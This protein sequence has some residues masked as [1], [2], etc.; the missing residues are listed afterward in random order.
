MLKDFLF[1]SYRSTDPDLPLKLVGELKNRGKRVWI[2]RLE[3]QPG[4][5]WGRDIENAIDNCGGMIVVLSPE[6]LASR[7]CRNELARMDQRSRLEEVKN[8]SPCPIFPILLRSVEKPPIELQTIQLIDFSNW[9]DETSFA[10]QFEKLITVIDQ[11]APNMQGAIPDVEEQ[12]LNK[13]ISEFSRPIGVQHYVDL[14]GL[15]DPPLHEDETEVALPIEDEPELEIDFRL[16]IA[17]DGW[18]VEFCLLTDAVTKEDVSPQ[19]RT[20]GLQPQIQISPFSPVLTKL[21]LENIREAVQLHPRFVLVGDPGSGKTTTLR[22]LALNAAIERTTSP[23]LNPLPMLLSLANWNFETTL[24]EFIKSSWLPWNLPGDP[25]TSLANG[26]IFL[27]LDGLNEMGLNGPEKSAELRQWIQNGGIQK[28]VVTCRREEYGGAL[29]LGLPIVLI[30]QLDEQKIREFAEKYLAGKASSFLKE[31]F[32]SGDHVGDSGTKLLHLARNPFLLAALIRVFSKSKRASSTLPRNH[33]TL[34]QELIDLLWKR[35]QNRKTAGWIPF[36]EMEEAFGELA[37]E[38]IDNDYPITVPYDWALS[39]LS[40]YLSKKQPAWRRVI[41]RSHADSLLWAAQNA[42]IIEIHGSQLKFYHQ[43]I[44]E[45]FAAVHLRQIGINSRLE[46]A[47]FVQGYGRVASKWDQVVIAACGLS[48]VKDVDA[49][50]ENI[51]VK[52]LNLAARCIASNIPV[53]DGLQDD[54]IKSCI[55]VLGAKDARFHIQLNAT[56]AL[57]QI[58]ARSVPYLVDVLHTKPSIGHVAIRVLVEIGEPSI[59]PLIQAFKTSQNKQVLYRIAE[60]LDEMGIKDLPNLAEVL[61]E[62]TERRRTQGANMTV[63]DTIPKSLTTPQDSSSSGIKSPTPLPISYTSL[64][65]NRSID[66]PN[67]EVDSPEFLANLVAKLDSNE[68]QV[69]IGAIKQL[70][71]LH[72]PEAIRPLT[73]LIADHSQ[74]VRV[75]VVIALGQ[76][77]AAS[78]AFDLLRAWNDSDGEVRYRAIEAFGRIGATQIIEQ[79]LPASGDPDRRVRL[80]AAKTFGKL[81]DPSG[82]PALV[83]A[84]SDS[85]EIRDEALNSLRK[86]GFTPGLIFALQNSDHQKR[87]WVSRLLQEF[88]W[89]PSALEEQVHFLIAQQEWNQCVAIGQDAIPL[90]TKML[91]RE[92]NQRIRLE[93]V[94]CLSEIGDPIILRDMPSLMTDDDWRIRHE[95]IKLSR[96][97]DKVQIQELMT[98]VLQ[99]EEHPQLRQAAIQLLGHIDTPEVYEIL[100]E[101]LDDE[102][103]EVQTTVVEL[104]EQKGHSALNALTKNLY[105]SDNNTLI[106]IIRILTQIGDPLILPDLLLLATEHENGLVRHAALIA[107][108]SLADKTFGLTEI[109]QKLT[110]PDKN[111][112]I[113]AATYLLSRDTAL[114]TNHLLDLLLEPDTELR[115]FASNQIIALNDISVEPFIAEL[116][117]DKDEDLRQVAVQILGAIGGN[118]APDLLAASLYDPSTQVKREIAETLSKLGWQPTSL[119][120]AIAFSIAA[121]NYQECASFGEPAVPILLNIFDQ[122]DAWTR[123]VIPP[124]LGDIGGEIS[125]S[126]LAQ[127]LKAPDP[128]LRQTAIASLGRISSPSILPILIEAL[129]DWDANVRIEALRCIGSIK[130]P[131]AI[132]VLTEKSE[133]AE[134]DLSEIAQM[135][136]LHGKITHDTLIDVAE[137][138]SPIARGNAIA[139]LGK[140]GDRQAIPVILLALHDSTSTV[141]KRAVLALG[142]LNATKAATDLLDL[143]DD[144]DDSVRR[145]AAETMGRLGNEQHIAVLQD[146]LRDRNSKVRH[147]AVIA[148]KT[149][150]TEKALAVLNQES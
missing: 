59:S 118:D 113:E 97:L 11:D 146:Q 103:E 100:I 9:Q 7:F 25:K 63:L 82:T 42:N 112:R 93:L 143:F 91:L 36:P 76:I 135:I 22:Y 120:N 54:I 122:S 119:E 33:G 41:Q 15:A 130:D 133:E 106:S 121:G 56:D 16:P 102:D 49:T 96:K 86:I 117:L 17:E 104:L 26:D 46:E 74:E 43:L 75:A 126:V 79:I 148:L 107:L 5:N 80:A 6:Y 81:G 52:D 111:V 123:L 14:H 57:I 78:T 70:G 73:R 72:N 47:H 19:M 2:D 87:L 58:G 150:G 28:L 48:D 45:Y 51:Y 62:L 1:I 108:N 67:V 139:L 128:A 147:A 3:I 105:H 142:D 38:M 124:I 125:V 18:E 69:R 50:I 98:E 71:E 37:F 35:E 95:T 132:R 53:R 85:E 109:G 141:R 32:T 137:S 31:I 94:R 83:N 27:Y 136:R 65:A 64:F 84:L 77:G 44:Q 34:F 4:A 40:R 134:I 8:H 61:A 129:E 21:R 101:N 23:R 99:R 116:L 10:Q 149:M 89:D 145:A 138:E 60:A 30:E 140:L 131:H 20:E 92:E 29:D 12:Y 110:D 144:E 88:K 115:R 66:K 90:L 127:I 13:V 39:R 68:D 114:L 55:N 24:F